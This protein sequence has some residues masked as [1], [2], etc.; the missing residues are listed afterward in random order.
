MMVLI[1]MRTSNFYLRP[2]FVPTLEFFP[3]HVTRFSYLHKVL[4]YLLI[5][6]SYESDFTTLLLKILFY[7]WYFGTS[8]I[9][10]YFI[11]YHSQACIIGTSYVLW[12]LH[13]SEHIY[14]LQDFWTYLHFLGILDANIYL[15]KSALGLLHWYVCLHSTSNSS[16]FMHFFYAQE[17]REN[18]GLFSTSCSINYLVT[19]L[20]FYLCTC[21]CTPLISSHRTYLFYWVLAEIRLYSNTKNQQ[22]GEC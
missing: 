13:N 9:F 10:Y 15:F 18:G 16:P 14:V 8:Y 5:N 20:L 2:S 17:I 3:T 22:A 4:L 1:I 6:G 7:I 11:F 21:N 19:Q 12:F